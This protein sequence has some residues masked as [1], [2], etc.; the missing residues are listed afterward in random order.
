MRILALLLFALTCATAHAQTTRHVLPLVT[1]ASNL[2]QVGLVRIINS[3]DHAGTI[4]IHA[5]DDAGKR[6]GPVDMEF[7]ANQGRQFTSR[8]LER[9]DPRIGLS[10]G[11]GDGEG[12]WRLEIDTSIASPPL[13]IHA[14]AYLRTP[15]GFLT[16]MHSVVPRG[17]DGRWHVLF[18]NP[19]SNSSLSSRLRIVNPHET[20]VEVSISAV[21]ALGVPGES[22]VRLTLEPGASAMLTSAELESGDQRFDGRFG[23]GAGKWQVFVSATEPVWVMNLMVTRSG[24]VSNLSLPGPEL[25][26]FARFLS[27]DG[28]FNEATD[29]NGAVSG[30]VTATLTGD[31]FTEDAISAGHVSAA[32]V[33]TGLTAQFERTS[34]TTITLA[35]TGQAGSHADADDIT[36][37]TVTFSDGAFEG[38]DAA[39]IGQSEHRSLRVDFRDPAPVVDLAPANTAE[40][41]TRVRGK[42]IVVS[43]GGEAVSEYLFYSGGRVTGRD[44]IYGIGANGRWTYTKGGLNQGTLRLSVDQIGQCYPVGL[45]FTSLTAGRFSAFCTG[46]L[47]G[48]DGTFEIRSLF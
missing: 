36:N 39:S 11:V 41:L 40:F 28:E 35:L 31:T 37:L 25:A 2:A 26:D 44:L 1:P 10:G 9:G 43:I 12:N 27:W 19:G 23:D 48:G 18:F 47:V 15:D 21:D 20:P 7:A 24:H 30:L 4:R 5:I 6:F 29:N 33:P 3:S 22:E 16:E 17:E 32:N 14:L 8:Q 42:K 13:A 38:G 46:L 34:P 45:L